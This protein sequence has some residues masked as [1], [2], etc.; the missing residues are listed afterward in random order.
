M[1]QH[2][3]EKS[4]EFHNFSEIDYCGMTR[5]EIFIQ[6]QHTKTI[7]RNE[8]SGQSLFKKYSEI[9]KFDEILCCGMIRF[10][11][12]KFGVFRQYQSTKIISNKKN[13]GQNHFK[14][15]SKSKKI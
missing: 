1:E 4:F 10:G 6:F 9:K 3:F 5:Q 12:V 8:I 13:M 14:K 15:L 7:V 11:N 2:N